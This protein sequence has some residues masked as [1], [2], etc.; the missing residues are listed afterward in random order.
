MTQPR[1]GVHSS[2][3]WLAI[4][5]S[6]GFNRLTRTQSSCWLHPLAR[7]LRLGAEIEPIHIILATRD[8]SKIEKEIK[9]DQKMGARNSNPGHHAER[10]RNPSTPFFFLFLRRS[11]VSPRTYPPQLSCCRLLSSFDLP[12]H[13]FSQSFTV[14]S[15]LLTASIQYFL[16]LIISFITIQI[17]LL[18][19][20]IPL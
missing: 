11:G 8:A 6:R 17:S 2:H 15:S 9:M 1:R 5:L 20:D 18:H 19:V 16:S 14:T 3:Q 12:S 13:S 10:R 7:G 4:A